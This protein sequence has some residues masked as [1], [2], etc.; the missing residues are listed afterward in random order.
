MLV[1]DGPIASEPKL[2]IVAP[3]SL[4]FL[5]VLQGFFHLLFPICTGYMTLWVPVAKSNG[6]S[7]GTA[8]EKG[9]NLII[10]SLHQAFWRLLKLNFV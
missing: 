9:K 8:N 7:L 6:D 2:A 3:S 5:I 10:L 1:V 4:D